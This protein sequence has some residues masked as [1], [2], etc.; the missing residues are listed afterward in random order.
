LISRW[1]VGAGLGVLQH[2]LVQFAIVQ[3]R[4]MKD[5]DRARH[6]ADL[7]VPVAEGDRRYLRATGNGFGHARDRGQRIDDA[8]R[9]EQKRDGGES[10][11]P[12]EQSQPANA[13]VD[14]AIDLVVDLIGTLGI[15]LRQRIQVGIQRLAVVAVRLAPV[16]S[17]LRTDRG[18]QTHQFAPVGDKFGDAFGEAFEQDRVVFTDGLLPVDHQV[19]D[20]T[21]KSAETILELFPFQGFI[22]HVDAARLGHHGIDQPIDALDV[23]R[24]GNR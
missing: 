8:P 17:G 19:F 22:R 21:Q 15:M 5:F 2:G 1:R 7:V 18:A 6:G 9:D 23:L 12:G 14:I 20:S 11:Q 13:L 10:G 4:A 3:H 24:A 16:A